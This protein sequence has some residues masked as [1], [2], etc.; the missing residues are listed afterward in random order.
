MR[1]LAIIHHNPSNKYLL[2]TYYILGTVLSSEERVVN[3]KRKG[4]WILYFSREKEITNML[5]VN[6][7]SDKCFEKENRQ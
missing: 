3:K 7:D 4:S 5:H 1:L 6:Y 2:S